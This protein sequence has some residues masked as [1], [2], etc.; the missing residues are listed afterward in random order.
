MV[1]NTLEI[2]KLLTDNKCLIMGLDP[3]VF[4]LNDYHYSFNYDGKLNSYE[5]ITYLL[6]N[7]EKRTLVYIEKQVNAILRRKEMERLQGLI[8]EK[9]R[10]ISHLRNQIDNL[11]AKEC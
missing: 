10:E 6:S 3:L 7:E 4:R 9:E 8:K 11:L 5:T 2:Q 1:Y